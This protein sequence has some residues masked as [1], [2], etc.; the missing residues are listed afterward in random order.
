MSRTTKLK[1]QMV[2]NDTMNKQ[3]N[4][5]M[6]K[7]LFDEAAKYSKKHGYG[8]VQDFIKETLREKLFEEDIDAD[9]R[10]LILKLMKVSKDKNLFGTE[11]DLM[12]LL[13]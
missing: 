3:I 5:R 12:R 9:E 1:Y 10:K 4:L 13:K 2:S 6:P 8:N 7:K 11:E